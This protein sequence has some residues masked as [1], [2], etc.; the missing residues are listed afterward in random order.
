M[1]AC[2]MCK[3]YRK[4]SDIPLCLCIAILRRLCYNIDTI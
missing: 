1:R 2:I 4:Q 3:W